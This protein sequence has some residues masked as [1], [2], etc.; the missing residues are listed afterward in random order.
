MEIEKALLILDN[1]L[2]DDPLSSIEEK[3]LLSCWEGQTY[4]EI[5]RKYGYD[6]TYLRGIGARLWAK[7]SH[8]FQADISKSNIE[9]F[10]K[11]YERLNESHPIVNGSK[12]IDAIDVLGPLKNDSRYYIPRSNLDSLVTSIISKKGQLLR[13]RGPKQSGKTTLLANNLDICYSEIFYP[14]L[15]DCRLADS[16]VLG[17]LSK[18]LKWLCI[19]VGRFLGLENRLNDYWDDLLGANSATTD[20][21]AFYLLNKI[22]SP[23]V[24][25]LDNVDIL[26]EYDHISQDF[27]GLLRSWHEK[28]RCGFGR[29]KI[30]SQLTLILSYST[31]Q[32]INLNINQSPFNIGTLVEIPAFTKAEVFQLINRYELTLDNEVLDQITDWLGGHPYLIHMAFRYMKQTQSEWDCIYQNNNFNKSIYKDHLSDLLK[33]LSKYNLLLFY[34]DIIEG[35]DK[36]SPHTDEIFFLHSL[37]LVKFSNE[38]I[39]PSC[40][41]YR[42][43]FCKQ[44]TSLH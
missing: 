2:Q 1:L 17:D 29:D 19:I 18:F 33:I 38:I 22:D 6:S 11:K 36:I 13:I 32:Y 14:C 15:I 16:R 41:L 42:E 20:Y 9:A 28:S 31:S 35:E 37:N 27:F 23:L 40:T 3:I 8:A 12:N 39:L 4:K 26:F 10:L 24:L 7:L 30:W 43:F 44:N 21:F 5:S 25:A 34:Q